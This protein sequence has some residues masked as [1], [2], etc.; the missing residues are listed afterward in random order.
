[1]MEIGRI[2]VKT[3]G[4]DANKKCVIVDVINENYVIIDGQTRR[5]KC[6]VK[7]LEP[8]SQVIKIKKNISRKEVIAEFKKLKIEVK[9]T[10]P[11]KKTERPKRLRKKK[12]VAVKPEK[13]KEKKEEKKTEKKE[14]PKKEKKKPA[15]KTT[16]KK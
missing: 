13:K 8:L 16:K 11:R 1:M 12:V 7:H 2:C 5:R 15:K 6:N 9:E 14:K 10:K 4:R 3:A